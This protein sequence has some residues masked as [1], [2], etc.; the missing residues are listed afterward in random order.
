MTKIEALVKL[1]EG[2]CLTH[3]YF[4]DDEYIYMK[5]GQLFD[6]DDNQLG[7]DF[8]KYRAAPGYDDGWS[9][10]KVQKIDMEPINLDIIPLDW[11][12][13]PNIKL[14]NQGREK[15]VTI[16]LTVNKQQKK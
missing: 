10:S 13:H 5:N 11:N 9:L 1:K 15:F 14:F 7:P 6:E 8:W 16:T 2:A 12:E 3:S 4:M